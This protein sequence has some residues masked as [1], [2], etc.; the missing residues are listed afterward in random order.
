MSKIADQDAEVFYDTGARTLGRQINHCFNMSPEAFWAETDP[1]NGLI[2]CRKRV[3]WCL[4]TFG[5]EYVDGWRYDSAIG[6][7]LFDDP[8][9]ELMFRL[10]WG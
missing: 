4:K 2:L 5:H 10:V 6:R 9:N 7:F 8:K 3:A 1:K